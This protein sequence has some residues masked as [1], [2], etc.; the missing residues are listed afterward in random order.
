[1]TACNSVF[2]EVLLLGV[3]LFIPWRYVWHLLL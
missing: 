3:I 1:M 2:K